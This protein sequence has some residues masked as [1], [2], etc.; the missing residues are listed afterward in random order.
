MTIR[1]IGDLMLRNR[2]YIANAQLRLHE[3]PL[4]IRAIGD[5]RLGNRDYIANAQLRL[6]EN[7][8]FSSILDAREDKNQAKQVPS[9]KCNH[10]EGDE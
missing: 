5:F 4:T 9:I 3:N 6:H 10:P 7:L 1:A 8:G 2:D